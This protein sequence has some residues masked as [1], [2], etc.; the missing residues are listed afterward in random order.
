MMKLKFILSVIVLILSNAFYQALA[1]VDTE[2]S[3]SSCKPPYNI[4]VKSKGL[5]F[6]VVSWKSATNNTAWKIKWREAET[7][8][9]DINVSNQI[10][11]TEYTINNLKPN[12]K[13]FFKIKSICDTDESNWS[14]E[15]NFITNLTNPS[16]CGMHFPIKDRTSNYPGKT[17]F[18]IQN[19]EYPDKLLGKDVF[20]QNIKLVISHTWTSDLQ[21][22]LKSPSGE[23]IVLSNGNGLNDGIGYGDPSDST[24]SSTIVFTDDACR[25]ITDNDFPFI[26]LYRPEEPIS[27]L[28]DSLSPF[29]TWE[30][31]IIDKLKG[32]TGFLEYVDIE[33]APII[34]PL[35]KQVS[36]IPINDTAVSINWFANPIL[37]TIIVNVDNSNE[38]KLL[39]TGYDEVSVDDSFSAHEFTFQSKCNQSVSSVSCP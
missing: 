35:P 3:L 16:D 12:T 13:Y 25:S 31:E 8:Y 2:L 22:N 37:D 5:D 14:N 30:L 36:I 27:N 7:D 15:Y 28:Y 32:N 29:G 38:I 4:R 19:I 34:C 20:I 23:K 39:N 26:G 10:D 33:F 21:I 11:T 18:K 17:Y 9:N 1:S 24:C 6:A